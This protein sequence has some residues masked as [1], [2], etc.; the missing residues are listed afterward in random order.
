[1]NVAIS[2]RFKEIRKSFINFNFLFG[3]TILKSIEFLSNIVSQKHCIERNEYGHHNNDDH[4][5]GPINTLII[6]P[7]SKE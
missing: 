4:W 7:E 2:E 1:M 6:R 3:E 5:C